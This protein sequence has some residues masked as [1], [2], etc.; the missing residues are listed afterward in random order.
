MLERLN[1]FVGSTV[2]SLIIV[3]GALYLAFGNWTAADLQRS[4]TNIERGTAPT[5]Q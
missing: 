5:P 4:A 2:L 3:F 1:I